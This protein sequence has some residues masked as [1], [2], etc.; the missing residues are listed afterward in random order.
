MSG[1]EARSAKA[2]AP[3]AGWAAGLSQVLRFDLSAFQSDSKMCTFQ[4][5]TA[6]TLAAQPF[7]AVP[8]PMTAKAKD[9]VKRRGRCGRRFM[10]GDEPWLATLFS[11]S[12]FQPRVATD[13]GAA[14]GHRR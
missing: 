14:R 8:A 1:A 2:S 9:L 6:S 3:L 7:Q 11:A 10:L 12:R 4:L 5:C 13:L